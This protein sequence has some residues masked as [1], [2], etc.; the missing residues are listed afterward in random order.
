MAHHMIYFCP[1]FLMLLYRSPKLIGLLKF[2][3]PCNIAHITIATCKNMA[4]IFPFQMFH[5]IVIIGQN[6]LKTV[7]F[8]RH[9][10]CTG[11]VMSP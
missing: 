10:K 7:P 4:E 11:S 2:W 5:Q 8:S 9:Q 3:F 6:I 1:S